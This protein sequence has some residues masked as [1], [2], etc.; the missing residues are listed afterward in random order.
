MANTKLPARLLDTSAIP[1]L[2]VTGDL[3][4]NTTT[5]KVD[6]T[7]DRV[8]I[9]IASP[10]RTLHIKDGGQIK[11]ES[12][13]SGGW[14]GLDFAAG[15]GTY[16]GYMGM[17][18]GNGRFFIDVD[19]NG[20]D[21][22]ILQNGNVGIND[23]SPSH[24]LTVK[25]DHAT[26]PAIK[27]EQTG[28]TDG[29]GLAVNNN[30]G[31]L[32]FSRI[33]GGVAGTHFVMTNTG[34][35]GIGTVNPGYSLHVNDTT[36]SGAGILLTNSQNTAGTYSDLKWQY[37]ASDSSYGSGIR[38]KQ[39]DTSNGGQLEF[40]TDNSSGTYTERMRIAE[41]GTTTI[42]RAITT[43]YDGDQGYPLHIQ[44]ASGNQTYL[45]ISVPGA[46]SGD[47]GL[48]LGHDATGTRITNRED[49]PMIFAIGGAERMRI[50]GGSH[51]V[52]IGNGGDANSASRLHVQDTADSQILIYETGSSP[53]TATLKLASQ[54]VTAYGANVQYTSQ[55]E[56][57]TIEN[58]GRA[59][60][61][62]STSGSIRFRT[63]VGNSSMAEVMRLQGNTGAVTTP[64]QPYAQL[65]GS[66]GWAALT[67]GQWNVVPTGT[68]VMIANTGSH[69]NTST[70]RFTCPVAG[71]Y[72]V[73]VSHYIYHP[74]ASTRGAQYIHPGIYRNGGA[75]WNSGYH[76][77]TIYGHNENL[78]STTHYDGVTYSHVISCAANDYLETRIY[79]D[80]TQNKT[81]DYYTYTSYI[82]LG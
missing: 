48:V 19:S 25:S 63:K 73:T 6:S 17:L 45:A 49:D 68:P 40:Y 58:F 62:S 21:L 12:T 37:S 27:I 80:G 65:R 71:K 32:E 66:G 54:S 14:V 53:Y 55:A 1:A 61:P 3:T 81:Y 13:S 78:S 22:T 24:L 50:A 72:M 31:R 46:A 4:V 33:G 7:N 16:D 15:N 8:G 41:D 59:L 44:A 30:E 76:P 56:Q 10:S 64:Q 35:V 20:E 23:T 28:N 29:W 18:D 82:L 11:L 70:K 69:Y 2:N 36:S 9:G 42:G 67:N 75:N 60:S 43:T 51:N 38:F 52:S 74:A 34:N 57:L 39:L 47:T 79:A 77:Y 5:L 26:N